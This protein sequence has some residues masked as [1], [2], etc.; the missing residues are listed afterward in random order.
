VKD[1]ADERDSDAHRAAIDG[2]CAEKTSI[3]DYP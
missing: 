3:M 1:N 2:A